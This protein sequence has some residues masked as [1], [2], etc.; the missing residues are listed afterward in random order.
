[1]EPKL[2]AGGRKA[3][4]VPKVPV[5]APNPVNGAAL[6]AAG[7]VAVLPNKPPV[8]VDDPKRPP[9]WAVGAPNAGAA[10]PKAGVAE[11][12]A[13]CPKAG[14]VPPNGLLAPNA[15]PP[16]VPVPNVDFGNIL[17]ALFFV[18]SIFI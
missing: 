6:T 8:D 13:G 16:A 11:V 9:G 14:C 1:M 17:I 3:E 18:H 5:D 2:L 12:A 4:L 10:A 7:C 15:E